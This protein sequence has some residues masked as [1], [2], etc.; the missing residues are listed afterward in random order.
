STVFRMVPG[1]VATVGRDPEFQDNS[2][3]L[4]ILRRSRLG[5]VSQSIGALPKILFDSR[6]D[7]LQPACNIRAIYPQGGARVLLK[8]WHNPCSHPLKPFI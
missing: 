8:K 6:D 1:D 4:P 3:S 7:F 5:G 2:G